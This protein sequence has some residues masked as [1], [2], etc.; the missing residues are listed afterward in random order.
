[1]INWK[2]FGVY[3][4]K[5]CPPLFFAEMPRKVIFF[6]HTWGGGCQTKVWKFPHF[7]FFSFFKAFLRVYN[8]NNC[9]KGEKPTENYITNCLPRPVRSSHLTFDK[10]CEMIDEC[11]AIISI[12]IH[13]RGKIHIIQ[14]CLSFEIHQY[15]MK[16]EI[17]SQS[18]NLEGITGMFSMKCTW[19]SIHVCKYSNIKGKVPTA[20]TPY[21]VM[22]FFK[23]E[24]FGTNVN[25]KVINI[26]SEL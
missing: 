11:Y 21:V 23:E 10:P 2:Y 14:I 6:F 16:D 24:I 25:T 19:K 12:E 22:I 13:R 3:K 7:F 17:I 18:L 5:K 4:G 26:N 1:M 15:N 8:Y 9:K 20:H